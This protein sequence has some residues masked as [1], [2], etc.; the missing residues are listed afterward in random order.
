MALVAALQEDARKP[1]ASLDR[2]S[3]L[4][5]G[6]Q[7]FEGHPVPRAAPLLEDGQD[8]HNTRASN[9]NFSTSF[10]AASLGGP[11]KICECLVFSGM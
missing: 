7:G 2:L 4:L 1:A 11:S 3:E 8:A 9:F 6:S 10:A 5:R